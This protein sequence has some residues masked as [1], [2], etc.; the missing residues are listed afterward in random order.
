MKLIINKNL[1]STSLEI[2]LQRSGYKFLPGN[3]PNF[4]RA[5]GR[6]NYPRFHVYIKIEEEK[7]IFNLHLDQTPAAY[8]NAHRHNAEYDSQAVRAEIKRLKSLIQK[9]AP[10]IKENTTELVE[11]IKISW[12]KKIINKLKT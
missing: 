2:F 10:V 5:I 6:N 8:Q 1:L 4:I 11:P 9:Q 12:W 3:E 7:I